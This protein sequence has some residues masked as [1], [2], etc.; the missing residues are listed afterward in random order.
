VFAENKYTHK[1]FTERVIHIS[2]IFNEDSTI[3]GIIFWNYENG[4]PQCYVKFPV[5][6]LNIYQLDKEY[7]RLKITKMDEKFVDLQ[8]YKNIRQNDCPYLDNEMIRYDCLYT[9]SA[10]CDFITGITNIRF[11]HL[12]KN[13][14]SIERCIFEIGRL[15]ELLCKCKPNELLIDRI[16]NVFLK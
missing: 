2:D 8:K 15:S 13:Y 16:N 7:K 5:T 4:H 14:C 6:F 10:I 12:A 9:S 3:L 11:E 1:I